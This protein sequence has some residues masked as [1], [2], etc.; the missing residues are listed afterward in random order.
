M[1]S[2]VLAFWLLSA[3]LTGLLLGCGTKPPPAADTKSGVPVENPGSVSPADISGLLYPPVAPPTYAPR[4]HRAEPLVIP[5]CVVQY[6]DRQ[7]V[8]AEVDGT[9]LLFATEFKPGEFEKLTADEKAE[10]V[11]YHP[12]ERMKPLKRLRESMPVEARQVLAFMDS[13]LVTARMDGA[14][15]IK[16]SAIQGRK[17]AAEGVDAAQKKY[18]DTF[19]LK[20]V[21]A[22][23]REVL[24]D[25]ITLSR[26]RENL[27]QAEQTIAKSEADYQEALVLYGRHQVR[28]RRQRR[29]PHHLQAHQRVREVRREDH[30]DRGHRQGAHR[31]ATRRAVHRPGAHRDDGDGR[32]GAAERAAGVEHRA[33]PAGH[34]DRRHRA[35]GRAAGRVRRGRRRPRVGPEPEQEAE[36]PDRGARPAAPGGRAVRRRDARDREG[37]ARHHRRRRRQGPHLGRG[38]PRPVAQRAEGRSR[39]HAHVR[40]AGGRDQPGRAILRHRRRPRRVRVGDGRREEAVRA[41]G[42][43]TAT[44]SRR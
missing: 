29:H 39:G 22:G 18:D 10:L 27:N 33:P 16:N 17:Y 40:R 37:H 24:D 30:G 28:S 26:F 34:R 41:A 6:E 14:T 5:N 4:L 9:I 44:R 12:H 31:G 38:Q 20:G 42:W 21:A 3:A 19:K 23:G 7:I 25:L 36:P 11:V 15:K 8:A 1:R 35:P 32:A 43:I 2:R 13:Q